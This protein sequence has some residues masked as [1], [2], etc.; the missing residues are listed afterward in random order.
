[1]L[2]PMVPVATDVALTVP[3]VTSAVMYRESDDAPKAGTPTIEIPAVPRPTRIS[4][5][6]ASLVFIGSEPHMQV[7]APFAGRWRDACACMASRPEMRLKSGQNDEPAL[8]G[9]PVRVACP[10]GAAA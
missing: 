2:A 1:M 8:V 10:C 4:A 6:A 7:L 9:E 3:T 5:I